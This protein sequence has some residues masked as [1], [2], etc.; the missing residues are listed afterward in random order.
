MTKQQSN[1]IKIIAM[2]AMLIDHV[3]VILLPQYPILRIIGRIAF[4]LF[5]Y[6]IGVGVSHTR[7]VKKYFLRLFVF[8]AVLQVFYALIA[9]SIG[10]DPWYLDIFFTLAFGVAAIAF[11]D[12]K[13]YVYLGCVLTLVLII[14]FVDVRLDYGLY[15][16]LLILGMHITREN[17][18]NLVL[19]TILLTLITCFVWQY[20]MQMYAVLALLFIAKPFSVKVNI[21]WSVF[22]L[23]YPLHLVALQL[24]SEFF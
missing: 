4:P 13:K 3:G 19:F 15:G 16:V 1:Y 23:F 20:P 14:G 8:G 18:R 2:L 22:Y 9:S 10:E 24:I 12:R 11:Y 6:Q 21:H 5:A 17:F 7:N